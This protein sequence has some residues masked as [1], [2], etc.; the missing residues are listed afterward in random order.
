[1]LAPNLHGGPEGLEHGRLFM[2]AATP[3]SFFRALA[4]ASQILTLVALVATWQLPQV[5][6]PPLIALAPLVV[7]NV[8]TF[9]YHCPRNAIMFRAPLTVARERLDAVARE[10]QRANYLRVILVLMAWLGTLKALTGIVERRSRL[11]D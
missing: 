9:A 3:A 2:S 4:P 8:V 6:W 7:T 1:V 5:R 10:R 11:A